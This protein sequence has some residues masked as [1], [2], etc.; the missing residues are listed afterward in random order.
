METLRLDITVD[1]KQA[2]AGLKAMENNLANFQRALNKA[3]D[4]SEILYLQRNIDVLKTKIGALGTTAS[5]ALTKGSNQAA[6]ALTNLG[7]VAQDAPYG[8]IGIQ[9]NL[10]PLLES[11]QSLKTSTGSTGMALKAMASGLMG[12]AG[13][14]IA[15]SLGSAALLMFGDEMFGTAK[16][17][18]L[19]KK[20]LE[21]YAS[22]M[23]E[24]NKQ[25]G[26]EITTA[27]LLYEAATNVAL[28]TEK[29]YQAAKQLRD[30]YPETLKNFSNETIAAGGA[31]TAY[32]SLTSS[33]IAN[34]RAKAAASKI[35]ELEAEKLDREFNKKKI[36]AVTEKELGQAYKKS[37]GIL[38]GVSGGAAAYNT[39]A[40]EEEDIRQRRIAALKVE[41]D[42]IK[43][44]T[45]TQIFYEKAVGATNLQQS[46]FDKLVPTKGVKEKTDN[47][48][49]E[50]IQSYKP[51]GDK[52]QFTIPFQKTEVSDPMETKVQTGSEYNDILATQLQLQD[53]NNLKLEEANMLA[54][55]G[56]SMFT[57]MGNALLNGQ[58]VGEAMVNI[59]K[60]MAMQIA[61]AIVQALIFAA[62]LEAF[63]ALKGVFATTGA[64][65]NA[66][67]GKGFANGG[68]VT[69]PA[70]GHL[71]L[72]HGTEHI[73][74]PD[75][76]QSIVASASQMG[77]NM[78]GGMASGGFVAQTSIQGS[79]LL[80]MIRRA[81]EN[82][83]LKRG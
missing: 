33:I 74:R 45:A 47:L 41:D 81:E 2:I 19:A 69:G 51:V 30:L 34:A 29:R 83:G 63:P 22:I 55:I 25:A 75:Q 26:E 43:K 12:P 78:G 59:F 64:I 39:Q 18:E 17:T 77:A 32:D 24:S 5:G 31:K 66:T 28:S 20:S 56:A 7:R 40:K 27:R 37:M 71:Q 10:N 8:F 44:L 73:M 21:G 76:L 36:M 3:T 80:L 1:N 61:A 65:A 13:L 14:G 67:G 42:A 57:A 68:T 62:L 46:A 35:A 11:F 16:K 50:K 54:E 70:S 52:L 38:A 4:S 58:D 6:F 79:Q 82:T 9:N 48:A 23:K 49:K 60:K 72:L 53:E 15:L